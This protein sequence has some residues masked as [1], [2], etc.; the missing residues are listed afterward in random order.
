MKKKKKNIFLFAY[1]EGFIPTDIVI[2]QR[3][4]LVKTNCFM[5]AVKKDKISVQ[6]IIKYF[7]YL[8][9]GCKRVE[10]LSLLRKGKIIR[11]EV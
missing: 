2:E 7:L 8:F 6:L 9:L 10:L 5:E 3:M 1:E 4:K 11:L